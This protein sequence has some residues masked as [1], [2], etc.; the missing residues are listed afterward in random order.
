MTERFF[1][2]TLGDSTTKLRKCYCHNGLNGL[3]RVLKVRGG[4]CIS[5]DISY[6]ISD[7]ISYDN[8]I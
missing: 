3:G 5:Y 8:I 6:D 7:D 2:K 4:A 1:T